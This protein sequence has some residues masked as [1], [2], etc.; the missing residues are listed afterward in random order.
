MASKFVPHSFPNRLGTA[1]AAISLSVAALGLTAPA[2]FGAT[3]CQS[4]G[5]PEVSLHITLED[6]D[7]VEI[8]YVS[9]GALNVTINS[10]PCVYYTGV[11]EM[12]VDQQSGNYDASVTIVASDTSRLPET[13][14]D[15]KAGR[16]ELTLEGTSGNDNLDAT[17]FDIKGKGNGDLDWLLFSGGSGNDVMVE[18]DDVSNSNK[19]HVIF[20]GGPGTDLADRSARNDTLD[21]DLPIDV[22]NY[23][24]A[25]MKDDVTGNAAVNRIE[26]GGG[27]DDIYGGGGNDVLLGNDGDDELFGDAGNDTLVGGADNDDFDGGSGTDVISYDD[28]SFPDATNGKG[29]KFSLDW[30]SNTDTGGAGNDEAI[31]DS[32]ENLVGSTEDDT[33]WGNDAV[34]YI[35]GGLGDDSIKGADGGDVLDG[36]LG[37]DLVSYAGSDAAVMVNLAAAYPSGG[38]ATGDLIGGF[39][40]IIGSKHNDMLTG[41][42]ADNTLN[43]GDGNDLLVGLGGADILVGGFGVHDRVT[44][45]ASA[46]GVTVSL[47]EGAGK[48]GDAEGDAL[49]RVED[50]VGTDAADI[51]I[52]SRVPNSISGGGGDDK[53]TGGIGADVIDGGSGTDTISY[54]DAPEGVTVG[55]RSGKA[56]GGDG[57][58]RLISIENVIGSAFSDSISGSDGANN[59]N[60]GGGADTV[61]GLGGNDALFGGTG[62]DTLNGGDGND[63]V[64]GGGGDD[65]LVGGTGT[66][67]CVPG[68]GKNTLSECEK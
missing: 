34:N 47:L 2:A 6:D 24:G 30:D 27:N 52:G 54:A 44:Y 49:S 14:L 31:D 7:S 63:K 21:Y 19:Y 33:L 4:P 48:G 67:A 61:Y 16:D 37:D 57:E 56:S 22:E 26:G 51:L 46:S 28:D 39:E 9:S 11:S 3:A 41:T 12:E 43:G 1:V 10:T 17:E 60:A 38:D 36:G 25:Q 65:R 40:G 59:I 35:D 15:L 53:I 8:E 42:A 55:L 62:N 68:P 58:D 13:T 66:D 32:V 20:A 23:I 64:A 18:T 50:V 29:V 5:V 45:A